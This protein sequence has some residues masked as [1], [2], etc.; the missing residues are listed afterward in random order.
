MDFTASVTVLQKF[1]RGFL[2]GER[3]IKFHTMAI[4]KKEF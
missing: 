1:L 2:S 4:I 3:K